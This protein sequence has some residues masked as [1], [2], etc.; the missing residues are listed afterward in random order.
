MTFQDIQSFFKFSRGQRAG[1]FLLLFL[2]V[3]VQTVYFFFDFKVQSNKSPEKEKWMSLQIQMDSLKKEKQDYVPK[4]YPFNPNFITDFKGYKLGMSVQEI[5][6]LLAFRKENKYVNSPEE[7]QH[8]TKVSDS[9]LIAIAPYFKF[10]DWVKNKKEFKENKKYP[11]TAFGKNEKIVII[12]INQAT[13]E[14]LIKIKGIGE[15]I[16]LRILKFKGSLGGF[17]SMEQMK[18]V[19]GLTPEVIESLNTHFKITVLPK[20]NKI[21]INNAS[22]KELSQF[23]YFNYQL[24]KQIVT[25]RSMNGDFKN[26]EDL[27]KIKGLSIEMANIIALYL[28]F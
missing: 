13:Q 1:V 23:P 5:D 6:R 19:W 24:A 3:L 28:D 17:V 15:V 2:I 20:V 26:I 18:D 11:F 22:I 14:D 25:F 21:D 9:L 4:I 12:D 7:F 16:S 10:P 8:V 27:T